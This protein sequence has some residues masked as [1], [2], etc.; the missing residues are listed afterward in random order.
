MPCA[1]VKIFSGKPTFQSPPKPPKFEWICRICCEAGYQDQIVSGHANPDDDDYVSQDLFNQL[2]PLARHPDP[3]W[4]PVDCCE[5]GAK[6][7]SFH[8]DLLTKPRFSLA[9][10]T[11]DSENYTIDIDFCPF[12]GNKLSR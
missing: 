9:A 2:A 1:H 6:R 12:C 7:I 5:R 4:K 3:Q 10:V 8:D 11:K